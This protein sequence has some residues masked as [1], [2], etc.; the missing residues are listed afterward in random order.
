MA[1]IPVDLASELSMHMYEDLAPLI[2]KDASSSAQDKLRKGFLKLFTEACQ[3]R[4]AMRKSREGYACEMVVKGCSLAAVEDL[5]DAC[6]VENAGNNV[7]GDRVAFTLFGALTKH[8]KYR[9]E[10]KCILE[11]AQVV[12]EGIPK[13][14]K[15][16]EEERNSS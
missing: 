11:K 15:P 10:G 9:G 2:S 7:A 6:A 4:M 13:D 8:P 1:A 16:V 5:A 14:R 3:F 12:V